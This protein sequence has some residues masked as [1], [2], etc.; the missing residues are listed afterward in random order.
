MGFGPTNA[1]LTCRVGQISA[2]NSHT[3]ITKR[4]RPET[5]WRQG[6]LSLSARVAHSWVA[7]PS[8]FSWKKIISCFLITRTARPFSATERWPAS[9]TVPYLCVCVVM[10]P[11]LRVKTTICHGNLTQ[12]L[13][14][15][16]PTMP[17]VLE[18]Y[19]N[20]RV[21]VTQAPKR[22]HKSVTQIPKLHYSESLNMSHQHLKHF[23]RNK[24]TP[25][26]SWAFDPI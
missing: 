23:I 26:V 8:A 7:A 22:S 9:H 3:E 10:R 19:G 11:A 16:S 1:T 13:F 14:R 20:V 4:C 15:K 17:V 2:L 25:L 21:P 6:F 24:F 12:S 18:C 5:R